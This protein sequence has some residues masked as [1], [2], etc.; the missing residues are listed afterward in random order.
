LEKIKSVRESCKGIENFEIRGYMSFVKGRGK[1]TKYGINPEEL[2]V[3][4]KNIIDQ[5]VEEIAI[6]I[7]KQ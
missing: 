2:V 6:K 3:Y 1:I 7:S 4:V 5:C